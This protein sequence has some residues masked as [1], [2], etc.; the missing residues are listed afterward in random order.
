MNLIISLIGLELRAFNERLNT[1]HRVATAPFGVFS[2]A[3]NNLK[4]ETN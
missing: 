2:V 4:V 1:R 3:L